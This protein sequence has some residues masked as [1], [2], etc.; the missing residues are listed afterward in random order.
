MDQNR[1]WARKFRVEVTK[2]RSPEHMYCAVCRNHMS[3]NFYWIYNNEYGP[4]TYSFA[5]N[6]C[7]EKCATMYIM[8][9]I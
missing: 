6:V 7:S 5:A 3:E 4:D 9:N 1:T 2:Y 8:R